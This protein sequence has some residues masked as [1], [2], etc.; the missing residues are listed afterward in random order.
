MEKAFAKL[1]GSPYS[2]LLST[3][4][5]AYIPPLHLPLVAWARKRIDKIC[6]SFLWKGKAETNGGHYLVSWS[7]INNPKGIGG[8][9]IIN[10]ERFGCALRLRW[11]W[12]A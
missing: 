2:R 3:L 7:L 10:L 8:L 9:G 4:V 1:Y 11:L 5:H 12:R 6:R